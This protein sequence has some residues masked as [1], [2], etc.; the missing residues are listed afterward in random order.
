MPRTPAIITGMMIGYNRIG[1]ST[2]RD[3]ARTSIAANSVPTAQKPTVPA[4]Q[5]RDQQQRAARTAAPGTAA[6]PAAPAAARRGRA[7]PACPAACRR[8]APRA[9]PARAA[10]RAASRRSARARTCGRAPACRRTRSRSTGCRRRHPRP[11]RPSL[12]K[13]NAKTSTHDT[14]KNSVV[15]R[16]SQLFD[17]DRDVLAQHEPRGAEEHVSCAPDER[18]VARAQAR[19]RRLR[20][21]TQAAVAHQRDA[22]DQAVGEIE[23]VRREQDDRAAGGEPRSRSA[24][25]PTARSSRPVNGSSNSTS[26]GPCS[27]AR[28]SASRWRMPRENP[29]TAS[30]PRSARPAR[31]ERRVDQRARVEAVELG[32]ERQV[33]PRRQLGIQV[34]LVREQ[35][36]AG[37]AARRRARRAGLVADSGPRRSTARPASRAC[38]SASTCRRRSARAGRRCRRRAR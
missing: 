11:A 28:S 15:V 5:Q 23:I 4:A 20:R 6:R 32:E 29:P 19:A 26:R 10:A 22:R 38:R 31:V 1:S 2:S 13:A 3:R 25:T 18:A 34:Q 21:T 27:S 16:I 36:D 8:R 33:L 7:A 24:T 12:T 17:L 9:A 37:A 14:A 35:A 30:S